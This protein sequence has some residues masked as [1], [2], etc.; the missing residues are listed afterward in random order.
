MEYQQARPEYKDMSLL[1]FQGEFLTKDHCRQY[2]LTYPSCTA[3][4]HKDIGFV[5]K[6]HEVFRPGFEKDLVKPFLSFS[7]VPAD[8]TGAID[9][10]PV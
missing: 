8:Y 7:S 10:V 3:F 2:V 5:K 9:L 4:T 6:Q 1:L